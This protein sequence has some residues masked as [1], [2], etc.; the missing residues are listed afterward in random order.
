MSLLFRSRGDRPERRN[1]TAAQLLSLD[2]S[3]RDSRRSVT[4]DQAMRHSTVWACHDLIARTV[5]TLPWRQFRAGD[6]V[7]PV[8]SSSLLVEPSKQMSLVGWRYAVMSSLLLRGN[9]YGLITDVGTNGHASRIELLHP[10]DVSVR[11]DAGEWRY[12]LVGD[13]RPVDPSTMW[14][15]A[16]YN[17]PGSPLGLSPIAHAAASIGLGLE[18][19]HH[20]LDWFAQGAH[21]SSIIYADAT[22]DR[23]Q[24]QGIKDTVR[25]AFR[26]GEPAVLGS[27]LE[28][29]P[30][31]VAPNESQ[32]L[33]T[34][35]AN[36][37][38]ICQWFGVAPE[39]VGVASASKGS[40]TYSNRE[41]RAIDFLT[42]TL[43]PWLVRFEEAISAQ[44]PRSNVVRFNTGALLKTDLKTRYE[45]YR[46]ALDA[47]SPWLTVDEVRRLED[48][49]PFEED[50]A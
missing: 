50:E 18:A 49:P 20:G 15:L 16:A 48:R 41:Q 32:F 31:Q 12:F 44:T 9:A 19:Q 33:D 47:A 24:A 14:H 1:L 27:G 46:L 25:N 22:L 30:V 8:P 42:F 21:P 10:D 17:S 38:L 11:R 4:A 6:E 29:K 7:S 28:W 35:S 5:A 23:E 39:M 13:E 26:S 37:S 36:A 43:R 45:S 40:I 3:G 34:I 2:R